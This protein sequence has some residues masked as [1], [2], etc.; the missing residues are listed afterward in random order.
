MLTEQLV[1]D[2]VAFNQGDPRRI[3]HF[4]KVHSFAAVIGGLEKLSPEKLRLLEIAAILHDIGIRPSEEKYGKCSGKLQEQ[5]G[6][7]YARELL[8]KYPEVSS[9]E[10][11]RICYLIAHHHTYDGVDDLDYQILLEAD[12]LVNAY[13]DNLSKEAIMHFRDKVFKTASGIKLLEV[14]FG[15]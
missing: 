6:P 14:Q 1:Q 11:E 9:E 3:Q 4:I 12:F 8:K 13:E 10:V 5:E 7:F 2:M 15:L